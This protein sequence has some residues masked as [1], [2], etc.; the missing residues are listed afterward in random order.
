MYVPNKKRL[1]LSLSLPLWLR[2]ILIAHLT[3]SCF[4]SVLVTTADSFSS[5]DQLATKYASHRISLLRLVFHK[6]Y[7]TG[8]EEVL[9]ISILL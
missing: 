4:S 8:A 2:L 3:S 9:I 7:T 1:H 5:L 6:S